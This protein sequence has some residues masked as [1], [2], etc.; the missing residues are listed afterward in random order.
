MLA[1]EKAT[2]RRQ[3]GGA[4]VRSGAANALS[5]SQNTTPDGQSQAPAHGVVSGATWRKIVQGSKHMLRVPR[6]AWAVDTSDLDRGERMGAVV[7]ELTDAETG[8]TYRAAL[9]TIRERGRYF[10]R[11]YG[12]QVA[13]D[14]EHWRVEA[15]GAA[16]QL[17]L[18]GGVL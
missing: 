11:G 2:A 6:P 18:M 10:E 4:A 3:P 7:L 14:L 13:L 1:T 5:R 17:A 16:R 9:R 12:A 8:T 15:P